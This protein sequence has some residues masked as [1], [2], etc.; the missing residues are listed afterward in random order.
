MKWVSIRQE[1]KLKRQGTPFGNS[2]EP[3][4]KTVGLCMIVKNEAHCIR[5]CL[6]SVKPLVD[7]VLVVD[8]GSTDGTQ[9]VIR[10]FLEENNIKGV[11]IDEPWRDFAWNRTFALTELRKYTYIDYCLMID[12]DEALEFDENVDLTAFKKALSHD[13]YQLPT[14]NGGII[15]LRPLLFRNNI[16]FKY[17]GVLHEFLESPGKHCTWGVIRGLHNRTFYDS[18]RN[19]NPQKYLHDAELLERTLKS[20]QDPF[21]VSRYT[22]YLAQSY[23]SAGDKAKSLTNYLKRAELGFWEQEVF[24]ALLSAGRL[25]EDLG[26][27][28]ADILATY[29]R[30]F[31]VC[32]T[33]AESLHAAARYCR[34]NNKF[35]QGYMIA[36]QGIDIKKPEGAALFVEPS[37]YTYGMLDEYAVLAYWAGHYPESLE[38]SEKLLQLKDLPAGYPERIELNAKFAREKIQE[39]NLLQKA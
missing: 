13:F 27:S 11:V 7:F 8:T 29:L 32:P 23:R 37:V 24:I 28:E 25:M 16:N 20:E 17:R 21:L 31:N 30:A 22:F 1:A 10:T 5:R 39:A 38:A 2:S 33:R 4:A 12:A 35:H 26:H 15:N 18:A 3:K 14:F 19:K 6:A 9:G 36:R 34:V